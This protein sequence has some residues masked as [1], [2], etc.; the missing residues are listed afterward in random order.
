MWFGN[1]YITQAPGIHNATKQQ[2][3]DP[4]ANIQSRCDFGN[5]KVIPTLEYVNPHMK[6][7]LR[8]TVTTAESM[9]IGTSQITECNSILKFWQ[10]ICSAPSVHI[11]FINAQLR[12]ITRLN[13]HW[14]RI[15]RICYSHT[16]S[17]SIQPYDWTCSIS[18]QFHNW[19]RAS[20]AYAPARETTLML[21]VNVV[22]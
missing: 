19:T 11:I 16:R 6:T 15:E 14:I 10:N 18:V 5:Q 21:G 12:S 2:L 8:S 9:W 20:H 3:R 4:Q 13:A 17:I 7:L 1:S 22:V